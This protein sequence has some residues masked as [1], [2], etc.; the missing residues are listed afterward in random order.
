MTNNTINNNGVISVIYTNKVIGDKISKHY[1]MTLIFEQAT[2]YVNI[3]NNNNL[4]VTTVK[5]LDGSKIIA[6]NLTTMVFNGKVCGTIFNA[7]SGS[8]K[9]RNK[10]YS[11]QVSLNNRLS[12]KFKDMIKKCIITG[13]IFTDKVTYKNVRNSIIDGN[14]I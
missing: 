6:N 8:I 14:L 13:N 10:V 7:N 2:S 3:Y 12:L 9:F 1:G 11:T 4:T 5:L